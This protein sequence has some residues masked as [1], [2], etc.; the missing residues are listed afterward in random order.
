MTGRRTARGPAP[1]ARTAAPPPARHARRR[2]GRPLHP[3]DRRRLD[4]GD[5]TIRRLIGPGPRPHVDD[6]ARV[7]ERGPDP[8]RDPRIAWPRRRVG[9]T[10]GVE[11]LV[12]GHKVTISTIAFQVKG[13]VSAAV[14]RPCQGRA[15]R[16]PGSGD[17]NTS[18]MT[19]SSPSHSPER[20]PV[21]RFDASA[22]DDSDFAGVE[23]RGGKFEASMLRGSD[24]SHA[25]LTGS[26][27]K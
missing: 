6:R 5:L 21:T 1:P 23:V 3:H 9:S 20:R 17:M 27:F 4:R 12:T 16:G 25:D 7:A 13:A 18:A 22:L 19:V 11:Q 10:D 26:S 24:F 8:R 15:G 14:S 2:P